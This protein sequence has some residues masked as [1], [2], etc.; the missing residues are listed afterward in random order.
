MIKQRNSKSSTSPNASDF[1]IR[2]SDGY[3]SPLL[4]LLD[5]QIDKRLVRTFSALFLII[6]MFRD[7][8]NGLVLS[9]L[10]AYLCGPSH[11]PAGTKRI[12][13]LLRSDKW[14]ASLI[15]DFLFTR[16]KKRVA[17]LVKQGKRALLLWDDSRLEKPES[18]F[19]EGLCSVYSSKGGRLIRLKPGYYKP[20]TSRIC[21]PGYKWNAILLSAL[22]EVPSVCQMKWWT[23][24][25]KFKELGSNVMYLFLQKCKQHFQ[26]TVTHVLDR[27]YASLQTIEWMSA[28]QQYFVMRWKKNHLLLDSKG[29]LRKTHIISRTCKPI[30]TKRVFDKER[31]QHKHVSISYTKVTH[32]ELPDNELFM[33]I[34]RDKAKSTSPM[35]LLTSIPIENNSSAWEI[36]HIYFHRW[37][38]EQAFRFCKSELAMESP[39]LWSFKNRLKFLAVVTLV[40]DFMMQLIQN[41]KGWVWQFLRNWCH[42]TG[43]R[44]RKASIPAYRLRIAISFCLSN[45]FIN[46][47]N[48]G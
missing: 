1:L 41:W 16:A 45:Y 33:V 17:Q 11:A 48:S 36:C 37:K 24:R 10:G 46:L 35:Y 26:N 13:N 25:G 32:P 23:T 42:R 4:E 44:Y 28:F 43:S 27:G 2:K 39:R 38:V 31:K 29:R 22:D 3:L 14:D 18:W 20:P 7:R 6:Q 5:A 9:E 30:Q 8:A 34:V 40:F 12:S 47:Q 15:D 19:S 21:V